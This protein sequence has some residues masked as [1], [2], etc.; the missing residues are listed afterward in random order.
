MTNTPYTGG[1]ACGA[2]RYKVT[3]Q[4]VMM[5]D[6]Q[7]GQCRRQ[8]GTG[9]GS[10]VTFV[11]AE[12]H[13]EGAASSWNVTGEGGTVKSGA[14]C[15]VCGSPV[16]TTFPDMPDVF[17]IRAGSLDD[18]DR[19]QPQL[20]MWTKTARAWDHVDPGLPAFEKMRPS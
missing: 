4:P 11:G 13:V 12:V 1:C 10:H 2:I 15:P 5:H 16:Y 20:I 7:C 17:V 3:G 18:P 6:C 9:H 14:F 19:Y 8:S